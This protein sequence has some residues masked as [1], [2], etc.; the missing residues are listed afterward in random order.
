MYLLLLFYLK[1]LDKNYARLLYEIKK[2]INDSHDNNFIEKNNFHKK[3]N[4]AFVDQH[5]FGLNQKE[6][7]NN[8]DLNQ[9]H[10]Y[11][12]VNGN[13]YNKKITNIHKDKQKIMKRNN[14]KQQEN[15]LS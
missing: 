7:Q 5:E 10:G 3:E 2:D 9:K 6:K 1:E 11:E 14:N 15:I 12:L 4:D 8:T 13:D